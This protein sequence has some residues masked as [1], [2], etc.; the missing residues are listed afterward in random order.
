MRRR[1]HFNGNGMKNYIF[2]TWLGNEDNKKYFSARLSENGLSHSY[3]ISGDIGSG[4]KTLVYNVLAAACCDNHDVPCGEC[5]FCLK[6]LSKTCVDIY[7]IKKPDGRVYIPVSAVRAI[8]DTIYYKPN[9]LPF[10]AYIIEQG[11][12]MQP[13][14]QNALLK[15]LEEPPPN[16][17]FF[18]ITTDTASILPTVMSRCTVISTSRLDDT[19]IF[20]Y[21]KDKLRESDA[22]TSDAVQRCNG[23]LGT[24]I[25]LL[26]GEKGSDSSESN[27]AKLLDLLLFSQS[28]F[29]FVICHHKLFKKS[30]EF[31]DA[32]VQ[33]LSAFRDIALYKTA[34]D[35]EF[36]FFES[37]AEAEKY[38]AS[39]SLHSVLSI[40]DIIS[41][42]ISSSKTATRPALTYTDYASRIWDRKYKA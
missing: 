35:F 32:Y 15:L 7:T 21:L 34:D 40:S 3:I 29:E 4:R 37:T 33:L 20:G 2:P 39:I 16:V 9:D 25:S 30:T 11:E 19:E 5:E 27:A 26:K 22:K 23:N 36:M 42:A 41:E 6:I 12:L 18:I 38:A 24:A 28:K 14:A 17:Y 31:Y 10:K 8:Y 1:P 13:A